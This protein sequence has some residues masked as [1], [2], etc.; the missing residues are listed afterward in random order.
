VSELSLAEKGRVYFT[1][2]S[3]RLYRIITVGAKN[4]Q[5]TNLECPRK[6]KS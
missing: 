3:I 2:A 1:T 5:K 6:L 4:T